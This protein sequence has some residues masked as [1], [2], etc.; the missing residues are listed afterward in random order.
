[1]VMSDRIL[2]L[3]E[4]VR[5]IVLKT[6]LKSCDIYFSTSNADGDYIVDVFDEKGRRW[7]VSG[8]SEDE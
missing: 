6:G 3:A 5:E 2:E 4:E 1:M 8:G 7:S